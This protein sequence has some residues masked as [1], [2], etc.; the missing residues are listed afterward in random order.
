MPQ[1]QE[2]ATAEGHLDQNAVCLEL[3]WLINWAQYYDTY[4]YKNQ[5]HWAL[6]A[7]ST[8][9]VIKCMNFNTYCLYSIFSIEFSVVEIP[10]LIWNSSN[11]VFTDHNIFHNMD[12]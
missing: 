2:Q 12:I 5:H 8:L 7:Q 1:P 6:P 4:I 9:Y 11:A 3:G 10:H